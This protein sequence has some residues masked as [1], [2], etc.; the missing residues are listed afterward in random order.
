MTILQSLMLSIAIGLS[1]TNFLFNLGNSRRYIDLEKRVDTL[2]QNRLRDLLLGFLK[3]SHKSEPQQY[4]D[5]TQT[6][7][8][9]T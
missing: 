1:V 8:D 5:S 3:D 6:N 9:N 4:P 2:M 7:P